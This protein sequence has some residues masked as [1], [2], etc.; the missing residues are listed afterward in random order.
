MLK[1]T[2]NQIILLLDIHRGADTQKGMY[3]YRSDIEAL[4]SHHLLISR[5]I[6]SPKVSLKGERAIKLLRDI[7]SFF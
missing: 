2:L 6:D 3:T 4:Y 5:D 1:L 7:A